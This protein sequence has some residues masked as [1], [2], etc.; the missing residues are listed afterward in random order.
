MSHFKSRFDLFG[1]FNYKEGRTKAYIAP[2][3][4]DS[5]LEKSI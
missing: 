2:A 1:N 5:L 4:L 3:N